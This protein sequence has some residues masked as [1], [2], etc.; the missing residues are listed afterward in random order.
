MSEKISEQ[1]VKAHTADLK[2]KETDQPI[3]LLKQGEV[4]LY[5]KNNDPLI[6]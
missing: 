2:P 3:K 4:D 1:M 6:K 5:K